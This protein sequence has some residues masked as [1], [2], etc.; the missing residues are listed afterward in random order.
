MT[1]GC[2]ANRQHVAK[3][4]ASSIF[5]IQSSFLRDGSGWFPADFGCAGRF[6]ESYRG[7]T[8]KSSKSLRS[9]LCNWESLN[10]PVSGLHAPSCNRKRKPDGFELV[11]PGRPAN[12]TCKGLLR[13]SGIIQAP[14]QES[15][16]EREPKPN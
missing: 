7:K 9:F 12:T 14:G 11:R 8:K 15:W 6:M 1:D 4:I 3:A 13:L 10:S 16:P 2:I 5:I